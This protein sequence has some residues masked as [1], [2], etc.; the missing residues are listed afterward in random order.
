[1][2]GLSTEPPNDVA[3]RYLVLVSKILQNLVNGTLPGHKENFM[4]NLNEFILSNRD[5]LQ[6]TFDRLTLN[7]ENNDRTVFTVPNN[8]KQ[9]ALCSLYNYLLNNYDKLKK[10]TRFN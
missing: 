10:T 3:Q 5:T 2:Y 7:T 9:A 1:V 4:E 8:Y 6:A